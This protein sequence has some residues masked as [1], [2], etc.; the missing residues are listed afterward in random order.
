MRLTRLPQRV[1]PWNAFLRLHGALDGVFEAP[2]GFEPGFLGRTPPINVLADE[3]G[4]TIRLEVPGIAPADLSVETH[5]QTLR[6]ASKRETSAGSDEGSEQRRSEFT[7]SVR[8][9]RDANAEQ[10]CASYE[11]GILTVRVPKHEAAK[12]RRIEVTV[13]AAQA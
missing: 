5:D 11:H 10:A 4:Y 2:L 6:L 8:L 13:G 12:P 7:R 3:G 1:D 9:P